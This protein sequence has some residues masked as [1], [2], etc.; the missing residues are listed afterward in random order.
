MGKNKKIR[1]KSYLNSVVNEMC[2]NDNN[3]GVIVKK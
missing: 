3:K 2:C 1:N